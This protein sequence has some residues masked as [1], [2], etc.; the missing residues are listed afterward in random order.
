MVAVIEFCYSRSIF[1]ASEND[2]L[3]SFVLIR[4]MFLFFLK[5]EEPLNVCRSYFLI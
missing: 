3:S 5:H 2:G 1:Y 4:F